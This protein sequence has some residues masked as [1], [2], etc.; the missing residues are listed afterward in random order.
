M[1]RTVLSAAETGVEWIDVTAPSREELLAVAAEHG[2]HAMSVEDALDPEHLPK[3]ER[4]DD[5]IFM[6]LRAYAPDREG[7]AVQDLTR[8]IAV[9]SRAEVVIT[10]HRRELPAV[11]TLEQHV[12]RDHAAGGCNATCL[13]VALV[14]D[15]LASYDRPLEEAEAT[16]R[17]FEGAIFGEADQ[18]AP[19]LKAIHRLKGRV[20]LIRRLL[21][22]TIGVVQRL[23]GP[24]DRQSPLF[25]DLR[26]SAESYHFYAEQILDG[27]NNLLGTYLAV[28]SH[29]T[30][31]VVRILTLFSAFFLPLT[32]IVGVY[33]MNFDWMPELRV[34]W[35]YPAVLVVMGG[36]TLVILLWFRQRGWL[37]RSREE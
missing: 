4:I 8:K 10:I 13:L 20:S 24:Q 18:P 32:F 2:L 31:D 37:R 25:Q 14:H 11:A 15:V 7:L 16:L 12:R 22:L 3:Y 34:W 19:N 36:I 9:F 17:T 35:G 5:S 21:W 29:R 33:G 30:N 6:I 26:E 28:A 27:A 1:I 23:S